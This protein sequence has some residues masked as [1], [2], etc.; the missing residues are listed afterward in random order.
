MR[1]GTPRVL[2]P[3]FHVGACFLH[4]PRGV[5]A[6][7]WDAERGDEADTGKASATQRAAPTRSVETR[8]SHGR[9]P[10]EGNTLRTSGE[11]EDRDH[12]CECVVQTGRQVL[13][14]RA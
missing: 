4:A 6:V 1:C 14:P 2:V 11:C 5:L 7:G 8:K 9:K 3:T 13:Q 12:A 10:A